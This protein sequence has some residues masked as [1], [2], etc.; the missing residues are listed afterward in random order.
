[1]MVNSQ[2]LRL[3]PGSNC[4]CLSSAARMVFCTRSSAASR[5]RHMKRAKARR[6]GSNETISSF[7]IETKGS[8]HA[9]RRLALSLL[10]GAFRGG[11]KGKS[12]A[13]TAPMHSRLRSDGGDA[14]H[15]LKGER[16]EL[17]SG[18]RQLEA[19]RR[20]GQG[21]VGQ[22]HRRGSYRDQRQAG[23]AGGPYPG[24]LRMRPR[25]GREAG[26]E[27]G[28]RSLVRRR[29]GRSGPGFPSGP[30]V[31]WTVERVVPREPTEPLHVRFEL[32]EDSG[33]G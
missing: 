13:A 2:P 32:E 30:I 24:A 18:R 3:V 17:G 27:L 4:A 19:V 6:S 5:S 25:R 29:G 21:E 1:M 9:K 15:H 31:P 20:K 7:N 33:S 28:W 8:G 16:H 26:Q 23:S 11:R 12:T 10:C 14:M 22:A